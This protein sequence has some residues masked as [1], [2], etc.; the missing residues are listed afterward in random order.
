MKIMYGM[1]AKVKDP[2][3]EC[4]EEAM[5]GLNEAAI[6]GKFLV[7]IFPTMKCIPDW[8]PGTGWKRRTQHWRNINHDVRFK[9]FNHVKTQMV[10]VK[11]RHTPCCISY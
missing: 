9:A 4:E 11:Q 10:S 6:P 8:F 1:E 7:D 5:K 2:Y 3:V